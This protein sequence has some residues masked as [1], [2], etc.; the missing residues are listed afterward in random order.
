MKTDINFQQLNSQTVV[1]KNTPNFLGE[2]VQETLALTRR[3]FIQL[4]RRPSTL[5]AGIIQPVM[6]L[7][8]FG[9][10]FQ[11]APQGL[12]GSTT[13]YGQF[14]AAGV[15]VFTA[16]AGALNAGLPVMFDR[17]FG[18]L[19]RLLVAPLAS[20]FSIVFA[21]AIFIISQSLLQA[22]VIVGA[23]AF[24]GAGLPDASGLGAIALIVF[25]LALGVTAIS[26]GLAF[27]L[28]GHIELIAVIFVTNLPLLFAST[29][30]APLSFMPGWLQAIATLNPLSYAIEP[31]RYLYLNSN[32]GLSDVVM[33]AFWGDV[34]FGGALLVLLGFAVVALLSI[35][36]QLRKTLA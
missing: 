34:T 8:L 36:P 26:L 13:N 27:A 18:F 4:Q 14:L 10:L 22:A 9:A 35:Q 12:F 21:S 33:H 23:A 1:A 5:A 6:W 29:A 19:N 32:W 7:V 11:N 3:L 15:I 30:L 31:I 2:I 25:L 16:F 17:E 24:L 20:R 28:P